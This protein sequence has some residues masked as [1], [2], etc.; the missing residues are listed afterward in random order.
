MARLS[1][2]AMLR[3]RDVF[4]DPGAPYYETPEQTIRERD[5]LRLRVCARADVGVTYEKV[6]PSERDSAFQVP[7]FAI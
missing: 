7:F 2:P 5:Q 6:A 1:S 4:P 3:I